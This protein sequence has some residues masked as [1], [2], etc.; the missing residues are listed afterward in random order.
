[1]FSAALGLTQRDASLVRAA[2]L[3]AAVTRDARLTTRDSFGQRYEIDFPIEN[4]DKSAT[5]VSAWLLP[6]DGGPPR[7]LTLFV[8]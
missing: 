8:R 7:M 6:I 2:L 4:G 3:Q 1:V 5:I